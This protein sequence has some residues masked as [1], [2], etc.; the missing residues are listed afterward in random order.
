MAS[1]ENASDTERVRA[2]VQT[3]VIEPA[4][5][6]GERVVSVTAGDVHKELGLKNRV[7]VVCQALKSKRFLRANH[8]VLKE[9]SGPPSGLSTTVRF[10]YELEPGAPATASPSPLWD[11]L[12]IAKTLYQ[13]LGGGENFL[14]KEREQFS[15]AVEQRERL[16]GGKTDFDAVWRSVVAHTGE[17]FSTVKGLPFRY[18][19]A[20]DSVWIER[21]GQIIDQTLARGQFQKAWERWPVAG[22]SELQDL[23]GPAYVFAILSDPRV[24]KGAGY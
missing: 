15:A 2:W 5:A 17:N 4:K 14:R 7:P 10:T 1:V 24:R 20:G 16:V 21:D 22:P 3:N 19:Q 12:G 8:L 9:V 6:R 23:R 13:D 11:L 18:V